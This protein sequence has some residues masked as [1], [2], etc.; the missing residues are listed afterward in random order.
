MKAS[1]MAIKYGKNL[2][3]KMVFTEAIG[4]WP[5]GPARVKG[6]MDDD[7]AIVMYVQKK[8]KTLSREAKMPMGIFHYEEIYFVEG[9]TC[10][11]LK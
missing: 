2:I 1:T 7:E 5:G 3:G 8:G 4:D 11:P 9:E 6:L 10:K